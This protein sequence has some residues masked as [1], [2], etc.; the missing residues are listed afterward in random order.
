MVD[1][2]VGRAALFRSAVA[3]ELVDDELYV[4]RRCRGVAAQRN[5][6]LANHKGVYAYVAFEHMYWREVGCY[7][8]YINSGVALFVGEG[9]ALYD[10]FVEVL[11]LHRSDAY[12]QVAK[13]LQSKRDSTGSPLLYSFETQ[14]QRCSVQGGCN[15]CKGNEY[16]F[17]GFD[18][19]PSFK[20][21]KVCSSARVRIYIMQIY[22][23]FPI[24]SLN[25]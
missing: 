19:A 14:Q 2:K 9:N 13:L 8:G 4:K 25:F 3:G 17:Y 22:I 16:V 15:H 23:E 7:L 12:G 11:H 1:A 18:K 20:M 10:H 5:G 24:S 6:G 21:R